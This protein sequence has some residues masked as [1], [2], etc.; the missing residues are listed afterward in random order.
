MTHLKFRANFATLNVCGFRLTC[1]HDKLTVFDMLQSELLTI[2][3]CPEN[4][5]ELSPASDTMVRRI[6]DA[7][8]E[9][10]L[11][12]SAGKRLVETIDGGLVR[13]DGAVL[14]PIIDG[15]PVLLRDDAIALDQ[16]TTD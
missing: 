15:I 2:L 10:R 8:R 4:H 5:S 9:G 16:L 11:T 13:E 3:C 1:F 6:N 7:I 14:Y 12:N